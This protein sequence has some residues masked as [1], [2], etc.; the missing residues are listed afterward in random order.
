MQYVDAGTRDTL[1]LFSAKGQAYGVPVHRIG[2]V[3]RRSDKGAAAASLV[4]LQPRDR[5]G[6][7]SI[8]AFGGHK[9]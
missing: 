5:P 4:D 1:L 8:F 6:R 9:F 2:A 7:S 3:A